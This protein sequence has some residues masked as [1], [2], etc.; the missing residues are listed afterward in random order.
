MTAIPRPL[1]T[2]ITAVLKTTSLPNDKATTTL[3]PLP[4]KIK[5]MRVRQIQTAPA[6]HG[7]PVIMRTGPA[8][9]LTAVLPETG[10][11]VA[12]RSWAITAE[13]AETTATI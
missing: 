8:S 1:K 3:G 12:E 10:P 7:M 6:A 11:T 5:A 4:D 2:R 9:N 13:M